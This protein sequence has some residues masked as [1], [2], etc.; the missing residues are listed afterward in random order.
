MLAIETQGNVNK[1]KFGNIWCELRKKKLNKK[2][3][4]VRRR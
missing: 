3:S 1:K 4:E 2:C